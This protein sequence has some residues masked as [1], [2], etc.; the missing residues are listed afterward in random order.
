MQILNA[1]KPNFKKKYAYLGAVIISLIIV[2]QVGLSNGN[3]FRLFLG[4]AILVFSTYLLWAYLI[5]YLNGVLPSFRKK[6][7]DLKQLLSVVVSVFVLIIFH[8]I[9]TNILYYSFITLTTKQTFFEGLNSFKPFVLK[10]IL[11]RVLDVIVIILILKIY[12][13]YHENQQQKLKVIQLE[14]ELHSTQLQILR[15]QL[16]PHFLFNSLHILNTLIGFDNDKA[17]SILLKIT[18]LLRKILTIEQTPIITFDEELEYF[19]DYLEIEQERFFDRLTITLDIDDNTRKIKIPTLILQP[20]I[21]NAFK[22]G[23]SLVEKDAIVKLSAKLKERFLEIELINSV[24]TESKNIPKNST[25]VGL[26]NL[27]EKLKSVFGNDFHFSTQKEEN[28]FVVKLK[29]KP[30]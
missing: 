1:K 4:N 17:Q 22:H 20:L 8:L 12:E 21:E 25:K 28:V 7:F 14:K 2:F 3:I 26:K 11:S 5:E 9:I 19:K 15:A 23:V 18:N 29:L 10:S 27:N 24:P 13:T 6:Y 30:L 16:N